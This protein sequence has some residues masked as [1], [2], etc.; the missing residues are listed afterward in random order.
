MLG[1]YLKSFVLVQTSKHCVR[2]R[3]IASGLEHQN[4]NL[5]SPEH[6]NPDLGSLV[7]HLRRDTLALAF[8]GDVG[9]R[10]VGG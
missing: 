3:K 7:T 4:P 1:S 8:V 10:G 5:G 9:D 2:L 6:Q